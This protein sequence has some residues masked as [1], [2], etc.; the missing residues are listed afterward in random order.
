[1][2]IKI[3]VPSL[4]ESIVEATVGHWLKK[5]GEQVTI[6]EPLVELETDKVNLDVGAEREGVLTK[7]TRAEG[8]DVKVG[9]ELGLIR[10]AGKEGSASQPKQ[11]KTEE[12][13]AETAQKDTD[14]GPKTERPSS[15][16][17][18][19]EPPVQ[20]VTERVTPL[21][22]KVAAEHG[23]NPAEVSTGKP[24]GK[25]T[26]EAVQ[27]YIEQ[28]APK[29]EETQSLITEQISPVRPVTPD[30]REERV[31]LSRRRR[32]IAQRLVEAQHNA[33]MLTTFNEV[34][35]SA[36]MDIRK[37]RKE[38]FKQR[39]GVSLGIVSFFVKA[40]IN[41]LKEFPQVNAEIQGDD[42]LLKHYYDIGIAIGSKEGLVVPVLRDADQMSFIDIEK[43]IQ[44]FVQ[45]TQSGT[46]SLED[47]RGGTFTITNG[48]V[49]GSL[50]STPILN[51]PQVAILGLHKIEDRPVASNGQVVIRPMMYVAL[52]YDHRLIDGQESVQFLVR[53]KQ[54]IE[55]PDILLL[56]G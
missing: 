48:G 34:D 10:E 3:I 55:N 22:R 11:G 25:I 20:E 15:Q 32:T 19:P 40:S 14:H 39:F 45:K 44:S 2:D 9:D 21:A 30:H 42:M 17:Q 43:E 23:I 26:R 50:L 56:E 28:Q 54:V 13:T 24:G 16:S 51:A 18:A 8:E 47:L 36:I 7:I 37:R 27:K 6:G 52:S 1:M 31:P 4:G 41:A 53:I 12:T 29:P 49:F 38:E 5:E 33:A 46:L 35:M